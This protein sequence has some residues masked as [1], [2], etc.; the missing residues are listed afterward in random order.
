MP[1]LS[2]GQITTLLEPGRTVGTFI[3]EQLVG[4]ADAATSDLTLPGGAIVRHA[5]VTRIGVLPTF[6]RR[7]GIA[8]ELMNHQLRDFA[9]RA[10]RWRRCEP[11]RQPSM[12]GMA[13][14]WPVQ[15]RALK[16]RRRGRRCARVSEPADR[17]G[18][19]TPSI[20]GTS[21]PGSTRGIGRRDREPLT[22]RGFGGSSSDCAPKHRRGLRISQSTASRAGDGIRPLPPH[23]HREVV[24]RRPTHHRGRGLLRADRRRL[25]WIAAFP[26]RTR[27]D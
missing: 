16:S 25:S 15:R 17:C 21:F 1:N 13:T 23:R 4:T 14:A 27:S 8:T 26:V 2:P 7:Q 9:A 6:R 19:S 5:A 12:N 11:R 10:R 3:D 18:Y 24:R 20:A 22:A